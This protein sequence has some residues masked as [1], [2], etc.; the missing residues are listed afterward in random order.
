MIAALVIL[1]LL[2]LRFP[3][4]TQL[5]TVITR[6]Y[7]R[8]GLQ[9]FRRLD[10]TSI[11]LKKNEA[12]LKFLKTCKS[13]E[14]LPKFLYFK[15]YRRNLLSSKLYRK[16]QFK[17]LTIEINHKTKIIK[18]LEKEKDKLDT[19][20]H[21]SVR[22]LDYYYFKSFIFKNVCRNNNR[23]SEIHQKKLK[24]LGITNS[25]DSLDPNKAIFNHSS[26]KLSPKEEGLLAYGL[27][28][29]LPHF[30]INFYKHFLSFENLY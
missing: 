26:R 23:T 7:G 1:F 6:R 29:K 17:L 3:R 18:N 25:L 22:F 5:S 24:S 20:L 2:K 27:N 19:E 16:W 10:K 13:Y 4:G 9:L 11:K 21:N 14:I 15:L 12:D 30:H 28:F 8:Q